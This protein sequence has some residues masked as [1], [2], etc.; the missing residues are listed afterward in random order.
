MATASEEGGERR[1]LGRGG[2][3]QPDYIMTPD[4]LVGFDPGR[5]AA[6][7][8]EYFRTKSAFDNM[9]KFQTNFGPRRQ[10]DLELDSN[11]RRRAQQQEGGIR[12]AAELAL[13]RLWRD[14]ETETE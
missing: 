6:E 8:A 12:P 5:A 3:W 2:A 7:R 1:P 4:G 14:T 13:A 10:L 9:T 11:T